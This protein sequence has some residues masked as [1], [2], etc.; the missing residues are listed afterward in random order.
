MHARN[1]EARVWL[2]QGSNYWSF[3][4]AV[5]SGV[6]PVE[7][8]CHGSRFQAVHCQ[9]AKSIR[10]WHIVAIGNQT[11][12]EVHMGGFLLFEYRDCSGRIRIPAGSPASS[13]AGQ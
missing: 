11:H 6:G 9:E 10:A 4:V 3:A 7:G 5:V 2:E 1:A 12:I 8:C 13:I